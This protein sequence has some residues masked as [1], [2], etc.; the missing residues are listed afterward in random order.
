MT[1]DA[2]RTGVRARPR[3]ALF[4]PSLA[5]GGA[6][7]VTL[8]LARGLSGLGYDIDLV[9]ASA[10]GPYRDAVPTEARV[11]DLAAGR[12]MAALPGLARYLRRERPDGL[13]SA[14]NH[15]NVVAVWASSLARY[16]GPVLVAEHNELP[17][18]TRRFWQ[19]AFNAS[20]RLSYPRARLVVAVSH[21]VKRSLVA[22][23]G[24]RAEHVEVIYNP[25]IG[26]D[27]EAAERTR[28]DAL[29][30][31][32]PPVILGVGRLTEQKN[33]ENLIRAFA[34]VRRQ[35]AVRLLILGEGPQRDAL[36]RLIAELDL[37]EDVAMPGFVPNPY[38]YLAHA[39]LFVLSSDWEGL[40]TVL[41]EA[42]ALGAGIVATDCPSG[43]DEIL[44]E[45][46]YGTLV[47]VRDAP[48][49]ASAIAA[50][51]DAPR[52]DVPASWLDQFRERESARRY[53]QAFALDETD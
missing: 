31:G 30:S 22:H 12:T 11:V 28:P 21:G 3:L 14:M 46:V 51:L 38:D 13:L 35:R 41:I 20:L 40:P 50:A 49:L 42:L 4:L 52:P 36:T 8:N 16:R 1:G 18:P 44:A 39:D 29:P 23:A 2:P 7:R 25:V 33:F 43:P 53:A 6:E 27:L 37:A 34:A 48:A 10:T 24:I 32:G 9:L 15:A 26:P 45:G 17:P 47:P 5:G 19:R